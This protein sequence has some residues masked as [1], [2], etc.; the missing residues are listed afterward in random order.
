M[1]ATL[2]GIKNCDTMKRARAWLEQRGVTYELHDY[3][4]MG[5]PEDK[6]RAWID[7]FGWETVLNKRGTTYRKLDEATREN[8][9]AESAVAVLMTN[10]SMIKRPV[11]EYGEQTLVGFD[12]EEYAALF[13]Q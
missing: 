10:S 5:V 2:Y 13:N 6:L 7:C 12:P 9:D 1:I 11:L 8:L 3:K 4:K